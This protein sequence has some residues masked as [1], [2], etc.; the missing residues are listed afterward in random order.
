MGSCVVKIH[1][2]L[3]DLLRHTPPCSVNLSWHLSDTFTAAL[4][5]SFLL[6]SHFELSQPPGRLIITTESQ[7][8]HSVFCEFYVYVL[9]CTKWTDKEADDKYKGCLIKCPKH[10]I[11]PT[12]RVISSYLMCQMWSMWTHI[13][14]LLF[15]HFFYRRHTY[16]KTVLTDLLN[17]L[18]HIPEWGVD[19]MFFF[20][21]FSLNVHTIFLLHCDMY[22]SHLGVFLY[23]FTA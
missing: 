20:C 8:E 18:N 15:L 5:L 4:L 16:R 7:A 21:Q 14:F 17:L 12:F 11:K 13:S 1:F 6:K 2:F 23:S 3:L 19:V 10:S 9:K 22:L